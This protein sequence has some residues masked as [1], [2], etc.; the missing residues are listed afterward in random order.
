MERRPLRTLLASIGIALAVMVLMLGRFSFRTFDAMVDLHFRTASRDDVTVMFIEPR[1]AA[2]T[3]E[4]ARLPGVV[5]VE[6]FRAVPVRIHG[7]HVSRR[8]ALLGMDRDASLRRLVALDRTIV[9][10]PDKGV[11]LTRKLASI[12]GVSRGGQVRIET[13]TGK[14]QSF[15]IE[16]SATVDE[17][18]GLGAYIERNE[19]AR[20]L[21]EGD[22]V[23]G[24]W[25]SADRSRISE[26][27]RALKS[28]PAISAVT[29]REAMVGSFMQMAAK[30]LSIQMTSVIFFACLISFAVIYNSARIALSERGR[31]LA[32]L[33]VLGFSR[34]EVGA[35]LLGEQAVITLL[36]VPLGFILGRTTSLWLVRLLDTEQFRL[37]PLISAD[38]YGFAFLMVLAASVVSAAAVWR[39]VAS[40]DLVE[41]LKTRE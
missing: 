16:V 38:T 29:Y 23:S 36:G 19:L 13:L 26:L 27:N 20:L 28:L 6:P 21:G 2:V 9:P 5:K 40:L 10:I 14:R 22:A 35:L 12:L 7:G 25:L 24:A 39:R 37:L 11:V 30:S 33:R 17:I 8:V 15:D 1:K 18:I 3:Y 34:R 41:V 31:D 32:T 4:L